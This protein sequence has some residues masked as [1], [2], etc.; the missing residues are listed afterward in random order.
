MFNAEPDAEDQFTLFG[1]VYRPSRPRSAAAT[2]PSFAF[3]VAAKIKEFLPAGTRRLLSCARHWRAQKS[4]AASGS[5]HR[6]PLP[7]AV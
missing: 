4:M 2:R 5:N 6:V 7:T 1:P 3:A